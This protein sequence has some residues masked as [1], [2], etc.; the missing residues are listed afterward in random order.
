MRQPRP[1]KGG[2]ASEVGETVSRCFSNLD[3][4][5]D[6]RP[7]Y[8]LIEVEDG[9]DPIW[10]PIEY[11]LTFV[12]DARNID[13]HVKVIFD[14]A[15]YDVSK[16][17]DL[18]AEEHLV[19]LPE[20][21]DKAGFVFSGWSTTP[22]SQDIPDDPAT[23]DIDEHVRSVVLPADIEMCRDLAFA[24]DLDRNGKIESAEENI[25][26]LEWER[27][28]EIRLYAQWE[29]P[30]SKSTASTLNTTWLDTQGLLISAPAPDELVE[31]D[32]IKVVTGRAAALM[33]S[34]FS[35]KGSLRSAT[36]TPITQDGVTLNYINM[37][38]TTA[39][40]GQD[41]A[42]GYDRLVLAPTGA[43]VP[44]HQFQIDFSLSGKDRHEPGN[45][46]ISIP[47]SIWQDRNG[48]LTMTLSANGMSCPEEGSAGA[49]RADFV[50]KMVGEGSD[51]R[52]VITNNKRLPAA[53]T[54]MIQGHFE[55]VPAWT[56]ED[57]TVS[58][59]LSAEISVITAAGNEINATSN[60]I[61][62]QIDTYQ[63][64]GSASKSAYSAANRKYN[65]YTAVPSDMP[66]SFVPADADQNPY[67]YVKWYVS[68]VLGGNQP[69]V[70]TVSDSAESS[71]G[72][73]VLGIQGLVGNN[74]DVA[75][76]DG[77]SVSAV[78]L[79]GWSPTVVSAYLWTA[80]PVSAF[81]ASSGD[82]TLTNTVTISA[83]GWDD[84]IVSSRTATGTATITPPKKYT[85]SKNWMDDN[86]TM[87]YRPA[88]VS[89]WLYR[90]ATGSTGSWEAMYGG[91]PVVLD[92]AGNW[93]YS[94]LD[95]DG[96]QWHY[97]V[98][99]FP[100]RLVFGSYITAEGE[101]AYA[102]SPITVAGVQD[103]PRVYTES[104]LDVA[105]NRYW[106]YKFEGTR[107]DEDT[108]TY[109]IDNKL[110]VKTPQV[111]RIEKTWVGDAG[112]EEL[113]RET[114]DMWI[115]KDL[116]FT[117]S[118]GI[119][120][121]A[122][123]LNA[124]H[125][126]ET[127]SFYYQPQW[128]GWNTYE[129][130]DTI[131]SG[132]WRK[133]TLVQDPVSGKYVGSFVDDD[134]YDHK[135]TM[136][137]FSD[138]RDYI[139]RT[140]YSGQNQTEE[141]INADG[142][143][144]VIITYGW[145]YR[146]N[147]RI[148][149]ASDEV[150][151]DG[152]GVA[153]AVDE[154]IIEN[155]LVWP[156]DV[157]HHYERVPWTAASNRSDVAKWSVNYLENYDR[158]L[159][160][161]RYL[162]NVL[163]GAAYRNDPIHFRV[164]GTS[165]HETLTMTDPTALETRGSR[166]VSV[167]VED[168]GVTLDNQVLTADDYRI[169]KIAWNQTPVRTA[170]RTQS[171]VWSPYYFTGDG[172]SYT[173]SI[174]PAYA[175]KLD[176][177]GNAVV[178]S[179]RGYRTYNWAGSDSEG[180]YTA[181]LEGTEDGTNWVEYAT[182]VRSN[183]A[184]SATPANGASV[185]GNELVFPD[186]ANVVKTRVK[187][188]SCEVAMS[189]MYDVYPELLASDTVSQITNAKL[190]QSDYAVYDVGNSTTMRIYEHDA[191]GTNERET[192]AVDPHDNS[193][194]PKTTFSHEYVHAKN[195]RVGV[196]LDKT[197]EMTDTDRV[198]QQT[199]VHAEITLTQ[200]S[201]I[202]DAREW[203]DAVVDHMMPMSSSGVYYDL[204]PQGMLVDL[205]SVKLGVN[206]VKRDV[207]LV[208]NYRDS[209]RTLLCVSVE[210]A[211][212]QSYTQIPEGDGVD[213]DKN[214][215]ESIRG[216]SHD[217]WPE[218]GY[219]TVQ[220][221]SYDAW[222]PWNEMNEHQGESIRNVVAYESDEV[223]LGNL[224]MFS[225]EEDAPTS[226]NHIASLPAVTSALA[227]LMTDLDE[228][229]TGEGRFV[230]GGTELIQHI[231]DF[232]G[233]ADIVK[234][235]TSIGEGFEW[236]SGRDKDGT[237][238][239][240]NVYEDGAYAYRYTVKADSLSSSSNLVIVDSLEN[241]IL[242]GDDVGG[243]DQDEIDDAA[244]HGWI[245]A[246]G[247]NVSWQGRMTSLD[248][249]MLEAAG[250]EPV[251]WYR[252]DTG[253]DPDS[254]S[255]FNLNGE[256]V[257]DMSLLSADNGWIQ[258]MPQTPTQWASVSTI[259][260]DCRAAS[261]SC[262]AENKDGNLFK[263]LPGQ[264]I[265]CIA[266][267]RAPADATAY[268]HDDNNLPT[269]SG[270]D[271][272]NNAH[273]YN[274]V[275]LEVVKTPVGGGAVTDSFIR[276]DY[277]KVGIMSSEITV[278]KVWNDVDD[279]DG[280]RPTRL[281][282]TLVADKPGIPDREAMLDESNEWTYT[283]E[284]VKVVDDSNEYIT[285]SFGESVVAPESLRPY[286]LACVEREGNVV[287]I[288]NTHQLDQTELSFDKSWVGDVADDGAVEADRPSSVTFDL[289]ADGEKTRLSKTVTSAT[290][291]SGTFTGLQK[292]KKVGGVTSEIE[293]SVVE[294]EFSGGKYIAAYSQDLETGAVHVTNTYHP[295]GNL[296]IS[297]EL[298][299]ATATASQK[300]FSFTVEFKDAQGNDIT[301][302]F[303]YTS[304]RYTGTVRNG[305][306]I[307]LRGGEHATIRE[308]PAGVHYK[309]T[310]GEETG[311]SLSSSSG[312]EGSIKANT[313]NT[314]AF[315]NR[316]SARGTLSPVADKTLFDS[317]V[318]RGQFRFELLSGSDVVRSASVSPD[319]ENRTVYR[320][321]TAA[322]AAEMT[323]EE[324]AALGVASSGGIASFG[325]LRYTEADDGQVYVYTIREV[326]P[327]DAVNSNNRSWAEST[328]IEK[329][330]GGYRKQGYL[331]D[332]SVYTL[333]V[334]P[335]DNGDG[336][337]SVVSVL[338]DGS[339]AVVQDGVAA[340]EN[341]Y[342]A[343]GSITLKAKK[344]LQGRALQ[345]SEFM[346]DLLDT[347]EGDNPR[348]T[349]LQSA[350][351][352][353]NGN[354]TFAAI[355]FTQ[356]DVG[357]TFQY[358]VREQIGG[359]NT[360]DYDNS[361]KYYQVHVFD[362]GDG[363]LTV[364]SGAATPVLG[365][366]DENAY[367]RVPVEY[368]ISQEEVEPAVD[369]SKVRYAVSVYGIAAD[370]FEDGKTSGLTFGPALGSNYITSYK[371]HT[372][373]GQTTTGNLHRCIHYDDWATIILYQSYD[374]EIY[375]QC[376]AEGC[377][378]S[379]ELST[380]TTTTIFNSAFN[381]SYTTGDGPGQ[382]YRELLL[383]DSSYENLRWHPNNNRPG[384][385]G[386]YGTNYEGWG[387]TRIRAMLNGADALTD[388]GDGTDPDVYASSA[389]SDVNKSASVYTSTNNLF[390]AFPSELQ[391]AIGARATKYDSV[392]NSKTEANLKTTYDKLWLLSPNEI[393][394]ASQNTASN[395]A[396]PL[397]GVQYP[398]FA[399][400]SLDSST[401]NQEGTKAYRR[402]AN[403]SNA[404]SAY[405]WWLRSTNSSGNGSALSVYGGGSVNF[406]NAYYSY[407]V[408]PG[409]ALT[410]VRN[411]SSSSQAGLVPPN[412]E[413]W[414]TQDAEPPI[415]TNTLKPGSL[416][417]AKSV[418]NPTDPGI[419]P[420]QPFHFK[421][422]IAGPQYTPSTIEWDTD[423]SVPTHITLTYTVNSD[424]DTD[425]G[426]G[427]Y[428][429]D[430]IGDA[431]FPTSHANDLTMSYT[432]TGAGA[433]YVADSGNPVY[434]EPVRTGY[435]FGG[436]YDNEDD[437]DHLF[438]WDPQNDVPGKEKV[439]GAEWNPIGFTVKFNANGGSGAMASQSFEYDEEQALSAN[440][441]GVPS[442]KVFDKWTTNAD[443]T[444][445]SYSNGA[446][447][448]EKF[449]VNAYASVGILTDNGIAIADGAEITLYA[450]WKTPPMKYAVSLYG[451]EVDQVA[452]SPVSNS[453]STYDGTSVTTEVAGLTFGPA[454]GANY[455]STSADTGGY[456]SH[457]PSGVT[458]SGN[459]HRCLHN[460]DW[461]TIIYWNDL[462]PYVYEQCIAEG[463]THSVELSVNSTTTIFNT[464]FNNSYT[465]GD[466]PGQLYRELLL[467]DSSYENLRWH[468]NNNRPGN[469]GTYGTNYEGWGAT[470]IRAM[471]NGADALTDLG[472]GT[473]PD[474]YASSASSD[475]N[476]SASV[477]TS[478]NNLFAA[479]PSELQSAIGA[480]ATKYDSV[481]NSKTEAN[482][483]TTYDKLWLLSP[484]EIWTASQNTASNYAH[485]LEG[486]QYPYFASN[487]LDSSTANQ[488]GTKAYRRSANASNAGSAYYWWLRSTR[489]SNNYYAL[490]VFSNGYVNY[491]SA[492]CYNGVA[493][494]FA[495][496]RNQN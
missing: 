415:F 321:V 33:A 34:P 100:D 328:D 169:A 91:D 426:S 295:F 356:A 158:S 307:K 180:D 465:T 114:L 30:V 208:E 368:D 9:Q 63:A 61:D 216:V 338:R 352:D 481:Y 322:E 226:T 154:Y 62:A 317:Q 437:P 227:P 455:I 8:C 56:I 288:T 122:D 108:R 277:T 351:N 29:V 58:D 278:H 18:Q 377:T 164:A 280:K 146:E 395:Y 109:T 382:L 76:A 468:P 488:E 494:G 48:N 184:F 67:V 106:S 402:S 196:A 137:E 362:N 229:S 71:Y 125:A 392:Y 304:D 302:S 113:R 74:P 141:R 233:Y 401:A 408:A 493:P 112:H 253:F 386:T 312:E 32:E 165:Y 324:R 28:G 246:S 466:G 471:L 39:S 308:I 220:T 270:T 484:N 3:Y 325:Q 199:K 486:V 283:F 416:K 365:E 98:S 247:K 69:V 355:S 143:K 349:V 251:V 85:V 431:E 492:N 139:G 394:T 448:G 156:G 341:S 97:A 291:W 167:E 192:S 188:T 234:E 444:G 326:I 271:P 275:F 43:N 306:V 153:G 55:S 206:D 460:D 268:F 303:A 360:V 398:Y 151:F 364:T 359:D 423:Y 346:F 358:A 130:G 269:S 323:E 203:N 171:D 86:N 297:K 103:E 170:E 6:A 182:F 78:M 83:T 491:S 207:W 257:M 284:H 4:E 296:V 193:L 10:E 102:Y 118:S 37:H 287:T 259:A 254:M 429:A 16:F 111:H 482:L 316:Y 51:A 123:D 13:E 157:V 66:A 249:S 131:V 294:R 371:A 320:D 290:N 420:A 462:D 276:Y 453:T 419:D 21:G 168:G 300:E 176:S 105:N 221:L 388:L 348:N 422:R 478:T 73:K 473:D 252:T 88:S 387:A 228:Q 436:W 495:L 185:V 405:Y 345:A 450:Q 60:D 57:E 380:N 286:T 490:Y 363:T 17:D 407:G 81:A 200:Q 64:V 255:Y 474:V 181:V 417:L 354:V 245:D 19:Q 411:E 242:Q 331:Y 104:E 22:D 201:N 435:T 461:N 378:H 272:A 90:S 403:A 438:A 14:D 430:V 463:C 298:L 27:D 441:F 344:V 25:S 261:A 414:T 68:G 381:A 442:G 197:F 230:Y 480:R 281:K 475:V 350:S 117:S 163:N 376:I 285:Y 412:V 337:M 235:V 318:R 343:T 65:V 327:D 248:L 293:Y 258:G 20:A 439:L 333:T 93:S 46:T 31:N 384:N 183:K 225:G 397:E 215:P 70:M 452:T 339:G 260:I 240:V 174:T 406:D 237:D 301:D 477:Y 173:H 84:H 311:F 244:S 467:N 256:K 121:R 41:G 231:V 110:Y 198:L 12:S 483:K 279:N 194:S 424:G 428:D 313:D 36:A 375:E 136:H 40:T 115:A 418:S 177:D 162:N 353:A 369:R 187:A 24:Y 266:Y 75:S 42:A 241:Y 263:L 129:M 223:Q 120:Y 472:D 133:V 116:M 15:V 267:M 445:L 2:G 224:P 427:A 211:P 54:V 243:A 274:N 159:H 214:V 396:H 399:S 449:D 80:Y 53:A 124:K 330:A 126:H 374:P 152:S 329:A 391:S 379:V 35:A 175:Y 219:K 195:Q 487:S 189:V 11:T 434:E 446:L 92:A 128:R 383:N 464:S 204:V 127:T 87:G 458:T 190:D 95:D 479:F 366:I 440:T 210:F 144:D 26:L 373:T 250:I 145:A 485:P 212:H 148:W 238:P 476:K 72:C 305:S 59:P 335:R 451:I 347:G 421:V 119:T 292:Y 496:T 236:G 132:K 282:V 140:L 138:L 413:G 142:S 191:D 107:Y 179:S 232:R 470:R 77:Q 172:P 265:T 79:D 370:T 135:Y 332:S 409:F 389:S 99:E 315:S 361:V 319:V 7:G 433:E 101:N 334:E 273:A 447:V 314:A 52:I 217:A 456:K 147:D 49:N 264:L 400:N 47:A 489:S 367:E 5:T 178:D 336:T 94:W 222:Y 45:I 205:N 299:N 342:A 38:W 1:S 134:P 289:Y 393:W 262:P 186:G 149:R 213:P 454:L 166:P 404:G 390:A 82:V 457:T 425:T 96:K 155:R 340:F 309:V 202:T 50:W 218:E 161:E 469:T 44:E 23:V 209:G 357:K 432:S 385:T 410:R 160:G 372:P 150:D 89:V 443:G 459:N 239:A 310:E